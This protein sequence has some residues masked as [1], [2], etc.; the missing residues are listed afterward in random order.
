MR[1]APRT[2]VVSGPPPDRP[3]PIERMASA[4]VMIVAATSAFEM[5]PPRLAVGGLQ[6][7]TL[8]VTTG[9]AVASGLASLATRP[10]AWRRAAFAAPAIACLVVAAG[11]AAFAPDYAGEAWRTCGRVLA[12]WLLTVAVA[13]VVDRRARARRV[14][15]VL[16]AVGALTGAIACLELAQ[17]PWLMRLLTA[18]RP[19]FHVVGGQLRASATFVYPTVASM[20]LEVVFALGLWFVVEPPAGRS[21]ARRFLPMVALVLV[22]AGVVASFTRAGLLAMFASLLVMAG[23]W[24][25]RARTVDA[26]MWRLG[27]LALTVM[28]LVAGSRSPEAWTGRV[29]T[30]TSQDWYGASYAVPTTLT[31]PPG[32][33]TGVPV[34]VENEGLLTW[35]SALDPIFAMSYHWLAPGS[36]LLVEFEGARTPFEH[37]VPPGG[38]TQMLVAVRAPQRPGDYTLVWDVV[39]EGRAWLSTEG[40]F[41][42]RTAV[43]VEGVA[44][45]TPLET[46]GTLPAASVRMPRRQLWQAA[47]RMVAARPWLGVG[48]GNFRQHYGAYLGL[49]AWDHRV[50]ANNLYLEVLTGTGVA[51]LLTLLWLIAAIAGRAWRAWR[52]D[53]QGALGAALLASGI[54]IAGHGLV[55]SFLAFTSTYVV[56]ALAAGLAAAADERGLVSDAHRV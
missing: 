33:L 46:H 35:Q 3:R 49:G 37:P 48:A 16:L 41:A 24:Y 21:L 52:T 28:A 42:P 56:F 43:R 7:S 40:V 30:D 39:H 38:R 19:G 17:V 53:P 47:A 12:A 14:I 18:F 44:P 45:S 27:G 29:S 26:A 4:A 10:G 54:T 50:H 31:L 5:V 11:S 23:L 55:D 8:E 15:G 1:L 20:F 9:L 6:V 51:G 34:T 25:A 36:D 2:R 13:H 22:S 32:R